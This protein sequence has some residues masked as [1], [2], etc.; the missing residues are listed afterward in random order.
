MDMS[1]SRIG[2]D[3]LVVLECFVP[4]ARASPARRPPPAKPLPPSTVEGSSGSSIG[5]GQIARITYHKSCGLDVPTRAAWEEGKGKEVGAWSEVEWLGYLNARDYGSF[6]L[7]LRDKFAPDAPPSTMVCDGIGPCT[8]GTCLNIDKNL[9]FHDRQ[10]AYYV[11]EEMATIAHY[12]EALRR[13]ITDATSYQQGTMKINVEIFTSSKYMEDKLMERKKQ[14]EAAMSAV[15]AITV[16]GTALMAAAPMFGAA[17][18]LASELDRRRSTELARPTTYLSQDV[19]E[20]MSFSWNKLAHEATD[21][22][23]SDLND[24]MIGAKNSQGQDLPQFIKSGEFVEADPEIYF[25]LKGI[26]ETYYQAAMVNSLWKFERA[27]ILDINSKNGNCHTDER[28]ASEIRVCPDE[29]PGHT[30]WLYSIDQS[31][32][33]DE[34]RN[35]QALVHGPIGYRNF[36]ANSSSTVHGLTKEDIVRSSLWID[37]NN[38]EDTV[39][40]E[41]PDLML[42]MRSMV[43]ANKDLVKVPGAFPLPICRNPGGEAIS[44]VW[45]KAGCNYLCKCGE[46]PWKQKHYD[47]HNDRT[48]KFLERTGFNIDWDFKPG[49][50]GERI[51][52]KLKHPFKTC[53]ESKKHRIGSPNDDYRATKGKR[54]V[55]ETTWQ[56]VQRAQ[57]EVWARQLEE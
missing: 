3:T 26:V 56:E 38:F 24:I 45:E 19:V 32:E 27:Y 37:A 6:P 50:G 18:A 31:E 55:E 36:F 22:I 34:L 48:R 28:G 2:T 43:D 25:K 51:P 7:Y 23:T 8:I 57:L 33:R 12:S 15:T 49:P 44:S 16:M 9:S 13:S 54:G 29:Y 53:N 4:I 17:G 47:P 21:S 41:K 30:Y 42:L 5:D 46:V 39:K 35:D 14:E 1:C 11:F 40:A 20:L 10:M 52:R